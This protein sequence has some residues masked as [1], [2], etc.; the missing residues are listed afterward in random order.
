MNYV[1]FAN[2]LFETLIIP[3]LGIG[4]L[5]VVF[6][7][8]A[9]IAD[10]KQS[11]NNEQAMKYLDILDKIISEAVITTN[12]TYVNSLKQQGK[13]DAEAQKIA[14]QKSFDSVFEI[15]TDELQE[16]LAL[17]IGDLDAY[18]RNKIETEVASNKA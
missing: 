12:Q 10:L 6:F 7:I 3:L 9:K 4:T 16:A 1:D 14:F 17:I 5:F 15:L 8:K 11:S 18:V 13:F 2:H